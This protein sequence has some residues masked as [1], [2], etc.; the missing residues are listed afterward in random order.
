MC[1]FT[2]L[3]AAQICDILKGEQV[4]RQCDGVVLHCAVALIV[5]VCVIAMTNVDTSVAYH[6]VLDQSFI[7]IYVIINALEVSTYVVYL[8][9]C[10][11]VCACAYTCAYTYAC[12][13]E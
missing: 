9:M 8:C 1:K 12:V 3:E 13:W 5:V 4:V 10:V 7:K 11:Y 2:S 6:M